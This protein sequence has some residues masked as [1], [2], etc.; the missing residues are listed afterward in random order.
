[1]QGEYDDAENVLE[2]ADKAIEKAAVDGR[3]RPLPVVEL[4]E[5]RLKLGDTPE[6]EAMIRG[7]MVRV[8]QRF[9]AQGKQLIPLL[10]A[11]GHIQLHA[12]DYLAAQAQG[13]RALELAQS[14]Y[15]AASTKTLPGL[16]LLAALSAEMGDMEQALKMVDEALAIHQA[17]LGKEHIGQADLLAQ[18]ALILFR[19]QPHHSAIQQHL[20]TARAILTDHLDA[21]NPR[22]AELLEREAVWHIYHGNYLLADSSLRQAEDIWLGKTGKRHNVNTINNYLLQGDVA[23]E[24]RQYAAAEKLY[25]TARQRAEKNFSATHPHYVKAVA[26]LSRAAY[27]QGNKKEAMLLIEE[28]IEQRNQF[29]RQ[30][31]PALSERE[32]ARF[33]A[34]IRDDYEYYNTVVLSR[35]KD[36]DDKLLGK[37]YDNALNTKALLLNS[38]LK[39]RGN[40]LNSGDQR[41]IEQFELWQNGKQSLIEARAS[42][43]ED[44]LHAGSGADSI[45]QALEKLEKQLSL[46]SELFAANAQEQSVHWQQV[47]SALKENE[48]AIELVRF[49]HFDHSMTDSVVYAALILRADRRDRPE[50]LLLANGQELESKYFKYYKNMMRYQ[51]ADEHCYGQYWKAIEEKAGSHATIFFSPDGVYTQMNPECFRKDDGGYVFDDADI[52]L[53]ANTKDVYRRR[54]RPT[55]QAGAKSAVLVGDPTFYST[56]QEDHA[57]KVMALPGTER[58]VVRLSA[59]LQEHGWQATTYLKTSALEEEAKAVKN[60]RVLHLA[61]HGYYTPPTS[62]ALGFSDGGS[63]AENPLL[64]S[65]LLLTGAGD[66]LRQSRYNYNAGD[67]IL[68]AFEAMNLHLDATDLVVLSACETGLGDVSVG[69]GVYGLQRAFMVAGAQ[70]LVMSMFKVSDEV[71]GRLMEIF[72]D[73]WLETGNMRRAFVEAKRE[74]KAAHPEPVFWG[75]FVMMGVE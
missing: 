5:I 18:K 72:Y 36:D 73:R 43:S 1:M 27:M 69:E 46:S 7:E 37:L 57:G 59:M 6:A 66:I 30:F 55:A 15:G 13:Q 75:A 53:V 60:P 12:G 9:G 49:R 2:A 32:K 45:F 41:L 68:T 63:A 51:M 44:L 48:V 16:T 34:S 23:Y 71:T 38:G 28:V 10:A 65:G 64:R 42:S 54:E 21:R 19:Q 11:L 74:I 67:G 40:I 35:R 3:A 24:K 39:M 22:G 8:E 62:T 61:T 29:I 31:F 25:A 33:W 70:L 50:V 47:K 4:A 17:V 56:A 52:V 26:A 20:T 14:V 58:E